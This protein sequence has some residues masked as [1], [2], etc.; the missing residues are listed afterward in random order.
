MGFQINVLF[1]TSAHG[2]S[3][4]HKLSLYS[5]GKTGQRKTCILTQFRLLL[6]LL[7][8]YLFIYFFAICYRF[9]TYSSVKPN[10][11]ST[12][13]NYVFVCFVKVISFSNLKRIMFMSNHA[14]LLLV[15]AT[16]EGLLIYLQTLDIQLEQYMT[17]F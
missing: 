17:V 9:Y 4:T 1:Y 5:T 15:Q 10:E 16:K 8:F 11:V 7:L 6:L 3:L 12:V 14:H 13:T 2:F